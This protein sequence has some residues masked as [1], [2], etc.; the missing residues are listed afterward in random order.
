MKE[1]AEGFFKYV[2]DGSLMEDVQGAL[3][4]V[5]FKKVGEFL[6]ESA[7][8]LGDAFVTVM[9]SID[10]GK[11]I[12]VAFD[13][14][15][16]AA[17]G[18]GSLVVALFG[19]EKGID[20]AGKPIKASVGG[21]LVDVIGELPTMLGKAARQMWES[22]F[23]GKSL[24]ESIDAIGK[25]LMVGLG[26]LTIFSSKFRGKLRDVVFGGG[27]GGGPS[28]MGRAKG[29]AGGA[30]AGMG[31]MRAG[32][33]AAYGG[34]APGRF[35]RTR[36]MMAVGK[37]GMKGVGSGIA[38]G[39]GSAKAMVGP[40][41]AFAGIASAL[42]QVQVRSE[43]I[44]KI[45]KSD[46]IPS[47]EKAG[48]VGEQ[49]FLGFGNVLDSMFLG[50]P[51]MVGGALGITSKDLSH[52]YFDMV[53]G[54][55][56]AIN[57]TIGFFVNMGT[58]V[59][60]VWDAVQGS[61]EGMWNEIV[62][63]ALNF[64]DRLLGKIK[65]LFFDIK[66]VWHGLTDVL[67]LP[68]DLL[69]HNL[70]KWTAD[71]IEKLVGTKS[72]PTLL[73]SLLKKA[74]EGLFSM[75]VGMGEE[76]RRQW[77]GAGGDDFLDERARKNALEGQKRQEEHDKEQAKINARI[78]G[79]EEKRDKAAQSISENTAKNMKKGR[80]A[81]NRQ[82]KRDAATDKASWK[83]ATRSAEGSIALASGATPEE[84]KA[85]ADAAAST[86]KGGKKKKGGAPT[87]AARAEMAM[88]KDRA[89]QAFVH[90]MTALNS[91]LNTFF[92]KPFEL[93]LEGDIGKFLKASEKSKRR[94]APR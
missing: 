58:R 14:V 62:T 28:L 18:V 79:R 86:G 85:T 6:A 2:T 7:S 32:A 34:V 8:V 72:D 54:F 94:T 48:L 92:Q 67:M 90:Q 21:M 46:V 39:F 43:S 26:G 56:V 77:R 76:M 41:M 80:E 68:F 13:L 42:N 81:I 22:I 15:V 1:E 84:A 24:S 4:Q 65:G 93:K 63:G 87:M 57:Q 64:G 91:T 20:D 40:M 83:A 17:V 23:A 10:W 36:G 55:E 78:A 38:K 53:A 71:F 61:A 52:F 74:D 33:A 47:T 82:N 9:H 30:R 69:T 11:V 29:V 70:R 51:S 66:E 49:A 75:A 45:M 73:G 27:E 19:G 16:K 59:G 5:N 50:L 25:I 37:A 3:S 12:G 35:R 31:R 89:G 60:M 44:S 88:P